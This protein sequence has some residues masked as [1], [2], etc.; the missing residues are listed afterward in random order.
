[1]AEDLISGLEHGTEEATPIEAAMQ[2]RAKQQL[3]G[4]AAAAGQTGAASQG[5][6]APPSS[7]GITGGMQTAPAHKG[8]GVFGTLGLAWLYVSNKAI[9]GQEIEFK[10]EGIELMKGQDIDSALIG[11]VLSAGA[12]LDQLYFKDKSNDPHM[13]YLGAMGLFYLVNGRISKVKDW[14]MAHRKHGGAG[15]GASNSEGQK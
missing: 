14:W 7:E 2:Q 13:R 11:E 4:Q 1:M 15:A 3:E 9:G 12:E 10:G 8:I 6:G 5:A